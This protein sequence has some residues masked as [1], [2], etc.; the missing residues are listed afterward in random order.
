MVGHVFEGAIHFGLGRVL[1]VVDSGQRDNGQVAQAIILRWGRV[2]VEMG[3]Y[4]FAPR[5][6]NAHGPGRQVFCTGYNSDIHQATRGKLVHETLVPNGAVVGGR[7]I[8]VGGQLAWV[9]G[10]FRWGHVEINLRGH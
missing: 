6:D 3:Q 2:E 10:E 8:P 5:S 1:C 9:V 7:N 4:L